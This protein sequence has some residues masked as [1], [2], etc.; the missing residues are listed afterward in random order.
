MKP[1]HKPL[2]YGYGNHM[3]AMG[4]LV[5]MGV[6]VLLVY[7]TVVVGACADFRSGWNG[8]RYG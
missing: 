1:I 3:V 4:A 6:Y 7:M 8:R 5:A 2:R